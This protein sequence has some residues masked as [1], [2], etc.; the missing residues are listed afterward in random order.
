[1]IWAIQHTQKKAHI[2]QR[3]RMIKRESRKRLNQTE[4]IKIKPIPIKKHR[5]EKW[6]EIEMSEKMRDGCIPFKGL[7]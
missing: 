1:M 5:T 7:D 4:K 2:F 6:Y 3:K